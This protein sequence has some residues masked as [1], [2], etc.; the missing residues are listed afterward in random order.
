M[1]SHLGMA[2]EIVAACALGLS[3][4]GCARPV[5]KQRTTPQE[6]RGSGLLSGLLVAGAELDW[7]LPTDA[8]DGQTNKWL[9]GLTEQQLAEALSVGL[10]LRPHERLC[11]RY[12]GKSWKA[13]WPCDL[14]GVVHVRDADDALRLVRLFSAPDNVVCFPDFPYMEVSPE[15]RPYGA[16]GFMDAKLFQ[17]LGLRKAEA[18]ERDGT[19]RL[20]RPV[21]RLDK[22]GSRSAGP[23]VG[24]ALLDETVDADGGYRMSVLWEK[25]ME[26]RWNDVMVPT[27][28]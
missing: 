28:R 19:Y 4:V 12:K 27:Y 6:V 22:R 26:L 14:R 25:E 15:G 8:L 21:V 10:P 20:L 24:V 18:V 16:V 3:P 11:V 7:G 17:K 2:M 23:A 5:E 13:S 9:E 1:D